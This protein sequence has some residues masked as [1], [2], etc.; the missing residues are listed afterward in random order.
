MWNDNDKIIK[1]YNK[2]IEE[3]AHFPCLCPV[4]H[5]ISAHVY[6]HRHSEDHCGIWTWCSACKATAHM[7]G[8]AP[9]WW[10]NPDFVELSQL[11]S[12]PTY[13]NNMADKIDE[14]ANSL[15][16][17]KSSENNAPFVMKNRFRVVLKEKIDGIEA[18]TAGVIVIRDDFKTVRVDFITADGK[19]IRLNEAPEKIERA[20]LVIEAL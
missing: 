14:W 12:D 3:K 4:C 2:A 1:V 5:N 7:S 8:K 9:I 15:M 16:H 11:C 6:I 18:G 17:T 13:L 10:K 19:T 20:A